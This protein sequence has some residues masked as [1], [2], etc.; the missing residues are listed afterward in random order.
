MAN[1]IQKTVR[2]RNIFHVPLWMAK[3]AAG[4]WRNPIRRL[5]R[6]TQI[7]KMGDERTYRIIGVAMKVQS[8][9]YADYTD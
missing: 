8:A 3:L 2:A 6:L 5:R 1:M 7:I 4:D 9:D